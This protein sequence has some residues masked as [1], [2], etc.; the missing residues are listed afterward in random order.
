F[1]S[2]QPL[3]MFALG[4]HATFFWRDIKHSISSGDVL[5]F[6]KESRL[7]RHGVGQIVPATEPEFWGSL[8]TPLKGHTVF[9]VRQVKV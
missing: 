8:S 6:G 4:C 1:E 3:V 9:V 2:G 5:V 7:M